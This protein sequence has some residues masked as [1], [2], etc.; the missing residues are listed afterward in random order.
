MTPLGMMALGG[1]FIFMGTAALLSRRIF[2][3]PARR[4]GAISQAI[5]GALQRYH[6]AASTEAYE[7]MA[8]IVPAVF[9]IGGT[10]PV[11]IGAVLK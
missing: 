10:Q 11:V 6:L 4:A 8:K 5:L 2:S 3:K 7:T 9:I 1:W